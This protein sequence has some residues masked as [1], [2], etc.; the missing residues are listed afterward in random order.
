LQAWLQEFSWTEGDKEA[1]KK[2]RRASSLP[3]DSLA[4]V[5]INKEPMF[6]LEVGW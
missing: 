2:E 4:A 5:E 6:V 3:L 1:R